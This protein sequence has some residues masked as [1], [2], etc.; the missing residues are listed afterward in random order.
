MISRSAAP[1][2]TLWRETDYLLVDDAQI[3]RVKSLAMKS[4]HKRA[5]LCLHDSHQEPVQEMLIALAQ[6]APIPAHRQ[7]LGRKTYYLIEG[8]LEVKFVADDG[9]VTAEY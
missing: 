1:A 2:S 9:N 3:A 6:G 4:P 5:R 8:A 7:R